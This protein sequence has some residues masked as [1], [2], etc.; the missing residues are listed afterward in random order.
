MRSNINPPLY[1]LPFFEMLQ[2]KKMSRLLVSI[3]YI[4]GLKV[5]KCFK[6]LHLLRA[7]WIKFKEC[8]ETLWLAHDE[9]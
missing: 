6:K 1:G 9:K 2:N 4:Y 3:A 5:K 7:S 8:L